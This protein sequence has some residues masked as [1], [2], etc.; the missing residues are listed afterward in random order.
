MTWRSAHNF[1][2]RGWNPDEDDPL[3]FLAR[4]IRRLLRKRKSPLRQRMIV[5]TAFDFIQAV[6]DLVHHQ[7]QTRFPKIENPS[8]EMIRL[9]EYLDILAPR[10]DPRYG[11]LMGPRYYYVSEIGA[12]FH[13]FKSMAGRWPDSCLL[14]TLPSERAAELATLF[15]AAERSRYADVTDAEVSLAAELC[16][17]V[18]TQARELAQAQHWTPRIRL[19]SPK[20]SC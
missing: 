6:Q 5:R 12:T 2:D 18:Y 1:R 20:G 10:R 4:D 8:E 9:A 16:C 17:W 19:P 7:V 13:L 11:D 3:R 15:L 14:D